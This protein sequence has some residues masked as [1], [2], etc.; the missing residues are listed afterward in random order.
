MK[1]I[2]AKSAAI[3]V[4][5]LAPFLTS[6]T[7]RAEAAVDIA[8][9]VSLG[10]HVGEAD[11][12]VFYDSLAP[13]GDWVDTGRYGLCWAPRVVEHHWRPYYYGHWVYTDYG[14]TWVGDEEWAWGPYHFGRWVFDPAYGWVWVPGSVWAPAWVAWRWGDGYAGWAPLPPEADL[15]AGPADFGIDPIS[16]VFVEE[17]YLP[18][19]VLVD[20]YV[21]PA[22]NVTIVNITR[23]VT[24]YRVVDNRVVNHG[25]PVDA[26]E[27]VTG[28]AVP[29]VRVAEQ[30][31]PAPT[32]VRGNEIV[33]YRPTVPKAPATPTRPRVATR[34]PPAAA[35]PAT[36][37]AAEL[38]R[39]QAEEQ[40]RLQAKE[41]QERDELRRIHEQ[42][43]AARPANV[44]QQQLE[45]RHRAEER[46]QA[47]HEQRQ[48][49]ALDERQA[50]ERK[51]AQQ[52]APQRQGQQQ[53]RN[54]KEKKKPEKKE[55][56]R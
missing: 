33:M 21:P 35:P 48:K 53:A 1:K 49:Q 36:V 12:G 5:L 29:R 44:S 50:R 34:R 51:A 10:F 39:R 32:R 20:R 28:R 46:A 11:V 30:T 3:S 37:D 7:V 38:N 17:R 31:A 23:N 40:Q 8:A 13:Y 41:A 25:V 56:P 14:W 26:V 2:S 54:D 15:S 42:E 6:S 24:N 45:E 43:K 16:F 4:L 47:E 22:R 9:D 19:P 52:A 55:Q 27:R 18:E